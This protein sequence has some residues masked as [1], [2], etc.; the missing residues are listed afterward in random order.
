MSNAPP[1]TTVAAPV[2]MAVD[3]VKAVVKAVVTRALK[4]A[5]SAAQAATPRAMR[6]KTP[7]KVRDKRQDKLVLKPQRALPTSSLATACPPCKTAQP[8]AATLRQ[9][10]RR[11]HRKTVPH[12]TPTTLVP[13]SKLTA[14]ATATTTATATATPRTKAMAKA[15]TRLTAKAAVSAVRVTAMA[16]AAVMVEVTV[17]TARR[18]PTQ[19]NRPVL[20]RTQGPKRVTPARPQCRPPCQRSRKNHQR[21]CARSHPRPQLT[22]FRRLRRFRQHLHLHLHGQLHLPRLQRLRSPLPLLSRRACPRS[23]PSSCHSRVCKPWRT[24]SACSG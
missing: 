15:K 17:K 21:L 22:P 16:A 14:T 10:R 6:A 19:V 2:A 23:P 13:T 9:R 12:E 24:A 5:T 18:R 8:V 20:N 1:A 4:V 7:G 11:P 3:V